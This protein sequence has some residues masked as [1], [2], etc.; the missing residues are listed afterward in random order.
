MKITHKQNLIAAALVC[1]VTVTTVQAQS[2]FDKLANA[3]F[4]DS[5]H[6]K[7]V[8]PKRLPAGATVTYVK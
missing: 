1:A 2:Q 3:P 8:D 4:K 6:R 7:C 5:V